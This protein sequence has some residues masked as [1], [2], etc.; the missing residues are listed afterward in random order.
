MRKIKSIV[1]HHSA[2]PRDQDV[3]KSAESFNNSHKKRLHEKYGQPVSTGMYP[4]VAYHY[5]VGADG[6]VLGARDENVVGYHAGNLQV[7]K[8]SIGICVIGDFT[9]EK[10]TSD[11]INSLQLLVDILQ[12]EHGNLTIHEHREVREKGTICP[13]FDFKKS[14]KLTLPQ[15]LEK[16]RSL[17]EKYYEY[18]K[19]HGLEDASDIEIMTLHNAEYL[20]EVS[21]KNFENVLFL[22]KNS[23][24]K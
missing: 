22:L 19:S 12:K 8:E 16:E 15:V 17:E 10:P 1:I 6:K 13:A 18:A 21:K 24:E 4:H 14:I 23:Y 5:L 7:N 11:Q 20:Q 9:K 3:I 2:T